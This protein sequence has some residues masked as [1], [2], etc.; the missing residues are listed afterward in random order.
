MLDGYSMVYV[1]ESTHRYL[2]TNSVGK[3]GIFLEVSADNGTEI[4]GVVNGNGEHGGTVLP[5]SVAL[6]RCSVVK[7]RA[8]AL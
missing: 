1:Y 2:W 8:Q 3:R 7:S 4:F 6:I 5:L